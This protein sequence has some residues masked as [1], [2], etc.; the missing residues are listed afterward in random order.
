M[1]RYGQI[2]FFLIV[3]MLLDLIWLGMLMHRFYAE[4][5]NGLLSIVDGNLVI[6]GLAAVGAY[7]LLALAPFIFI[8]P[9]ANKETPVKWYAIQGALMGLVIYGVYNFTNK[10]ILLQYG[11][12]L[13]LIDTLWGMVIY[14]VSTAVT[15]YYIPSKKSS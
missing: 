8:F 12:P 1:N 2:F 7:I 15:G 11:W 14:G 9:Y 13:T 6:N 4:Q 10:A 3:F 5:M